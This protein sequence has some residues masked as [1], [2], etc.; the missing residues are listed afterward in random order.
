MSAMVKRNATLDNYKIFLSILVILLHYFIPFMSDSQIRHNVSAAIWLPVYSIRQLGRLA[1]PS[2]FLMSG[3][4]LAFSNKQKIQGYLKKQLKCYLVWSAFYALFWLHNPHHMLVICLNA[5]FGY[6]HLWYIAALIVAVP[7]YCCLSYWTDNAVLLSGVAVILFITGYLLQTHYFYNHHPYSIFFY[8]NTLFFCLP[9]LILGDLLKRWS[10]SLPGRRY[11][12]LLL[13]S[14]LMLFGSECFYYGHAGREYD[15]YL[16]TLIVCPAIFVFLLQNSRYIVAPSSKQDW[17]SALYFSHI[18][19]YSGMCFFVLNQKPD[20]SVVL[21][22][23]YFILCLINSYLFIKI[24]KK[25][26]IFF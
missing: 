10:D 22:P 17:F 8:R 6:F 13:L 11:V 4:F 23:V 2:F 21:L 9:F 16:S 24:N 3:Y 12:V 18:A 19:V 26:P 20:L 14:G 1:V 15:L 5:V 25:I 7:L